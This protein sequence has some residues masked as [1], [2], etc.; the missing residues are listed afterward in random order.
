MNILNSILTIARSVLRYNDEYM[1]MSRQVDLA[2]KYYDE[3]NKVEFYK[4]AKEL[5]D[6]H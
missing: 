5:L 1:E 4:L 3:G 2:L 6:L